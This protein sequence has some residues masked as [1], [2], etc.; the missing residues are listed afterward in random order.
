[1]NNV[2]NPESE[3]SRGRELTIFERAVVRE[4]APIRRGEGRL[5]LH[6]GGLDFLLLTVF[7][8]LRRRSLAALEAYPWFQ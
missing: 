7:F 3:V 6:D 2:P 1:M 8:S 4:L 5:L